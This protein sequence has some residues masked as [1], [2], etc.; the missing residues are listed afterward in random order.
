MKARDITQDALASATGVSQ[1]AVGRWLQGSIPAG[2][3]LFRIAAFFDVQMESLLGGEAGQ[4]ARE[5]AAV[6]KAR[7][8]FQAKRG[9]D[10]ASIARKLRALADE[11]DPPGQSQSQSQ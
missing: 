7:A 4:I 11:L 8:S 9:G 6:A 2:D 1:P 3:T 5:H 10:P